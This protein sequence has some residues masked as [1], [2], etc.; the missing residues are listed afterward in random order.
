[1]ITASLVCVRVGG[2]TGLEHF[3][4]HMHTIVC[5]Q[6]TPFAYVHL[7]PSV[8]AASSE[9]VRSIVCHPATSVGARELRRV[10]YLV[11]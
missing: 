4:P 3:H 9:Y 8:Q 7:S 6:T 10:M 1:M 2:Y 5:A 11:R